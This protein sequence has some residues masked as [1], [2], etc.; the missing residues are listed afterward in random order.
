MATHTKVFRSGTDQLVFNRIY[1]DSVSSK[2]A[3]ERV[4]SYIESEN[5][6]HFGK[7]DYKIFNARYERYVLS[8][9]LR[10]G[11]SGETESAHIVEND[12]TSWC[13]LALTNVFESTVR[14]RETCFVCAEKAGVLH[15]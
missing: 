13:G 7:L 9:S 5:L 2:E 8:K 14:F 3:G 6:S 15:V 12:S 4:K 11:I 1:P 10:Y